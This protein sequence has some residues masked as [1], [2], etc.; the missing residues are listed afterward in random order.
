MTDLLL[1]VL[2]FVCPLLLLVLPCVMAFGLISPWPVAMK[3]FGASSASGALLIG[4]HYESRSSGNTSYEKREQTYALLPGLKTVTVIQ[5]NGEVRT[6]EDSNGLLSLLAIYVLLG[7]G[8]W[9][10]WFRPKKREHTH[11]GR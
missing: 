1:R 6:E 4:A 3:V 7:V 8:T 11:A 9:W 2:K 10:F 5:E